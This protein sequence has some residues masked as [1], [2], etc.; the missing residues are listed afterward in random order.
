MQH[1][2][3]RYA[4]YSILE[5][6]GFGDRAQT[7]YQAASLTGWDGVP[8]NLPQRLLECA[9]SLPLDVGVGDAPGIPGPIPD[10]KQELAQ[11][12]FELIIDHPAHIGT[13]AA[14]LQAL[15]A[16]W[17]HATREE[18]LRL[19]RCWYASVL[20]HQAPEDSVLSRARLR[21]WQRHQPTFYNL[22]PGTP[23]TLV[24]MLGERTAAGAYAVLS[25]YLGPDTDLATLAWTLGLC[26]QQVILQR[27]DRPGIAQQALLG[28]V[29][30]EML[31][32]YTP[33]EHLMT[34]LSQLAHQ[35][36]WCYHHANM[37]GPEAGSRDTGLHLID[38]IRQGD[39]TASQRAARQAAQQPARLWSCLF[40]ALNGFLD[41][42]NPHWPRALTAITTTIARSGRNALCPEDAA[43]AGAS[44]AALA[45]LHAEQS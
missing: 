22:T 33:P 28:T 3:A 35:M 4:I 40:K 12:V 39:Y 29:A 42:C 11:Q 15:V 6:T 44:L 2:A 19:R 8:V 38:A 16:L 45:H 7:L 21:Q 37:P 26:A 17:P 30:A 27:F 14:N 10:S 34:L 43:T 23:S 9:S 1:V 5:G 25:T 32:P 36:W 41:D 24:T 31:A 13:Q 20:R 18:R